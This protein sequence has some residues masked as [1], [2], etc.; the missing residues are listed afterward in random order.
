[1]ASCPGPFWFWTVVQ[2]PTDLGPIDLQAI[3]LMR[4]VLMPTG[5]KPV[6]LS[7]V[8]LRP[9]GFV[10]GLGTAFSRMERNSVER[11]LHIYKF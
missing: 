5:L 9:F 1:M 2:G 7:P 10:T 3:G 4:A 11:R 8:G 6:G